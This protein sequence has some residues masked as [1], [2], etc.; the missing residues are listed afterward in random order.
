MLTILSPGPLS[1]IQDLGR[2]GHQHLGVSS[3]GPM[4]MHAFLWANRLL[5]NP[6][7]TACIEITIGMFKAQFERAT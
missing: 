2:T 7:N 1:L 3:G 6:V 5:D 4:D